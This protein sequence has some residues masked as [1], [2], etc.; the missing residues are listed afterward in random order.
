METIKPSR[1][2]SLESSQSLS[3]PLSLEAASQR[4][5]G[6]LQVLSQP[7]NSHAEGEQERAILDGFS[8]QPDLHIVPFTARIHSR[9][10]LL[11]RCSPL[12]HFSLEQVQT[13]SYATRM[14]EYISVQMADGLVDVTNTTSDQ[15]EDIGRWTDVKVTFSA[16]GQEADDL[17][18][19][20]AFEVSISYKSNGTK[21]EA[22]AVFIPAIKEANTDDTNDQAKDITYY[23]LLFTKAPIRLTTLITTFFE[24]EF[25]CRIMRLRLSSQ[26]LVGLLDIWQQLILAEDAVQ[27]ITKPLQITFGFPERIRDLKTVTLTL[28]PE[29]VRHMFQS[30]RDQ[31]NPH[32][33]LQNVIRSHV[34]HHLRIDVLHLHLVRI[35]MDIGLISAEGKAKFSPH[36]TQQQEYLLRWLAM[37]AGSLSW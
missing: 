29:D 27:D 20:G 21:Q 17:R 14:K 3:Q 34:L 7:L 28:Q 16:V 15:P 8:G 5:D 10:L 4:T 30:I 6:S 31:A 13:T 18:T 24:T 12:F 35:G 1:L 22:L 36:R 11:H 23:P 25:D 2:S 19:T 32:I 26:Q 33:T 37:A 9:T